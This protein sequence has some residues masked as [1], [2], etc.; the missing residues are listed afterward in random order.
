MDFMGC[1]LVEHEDEKTKKI[2]IK[3]EYLGGKQ[4]LN[5]IED[6]LLYNSHNHLRIMR[7]LA[8]L[9]IT[10]MRKYAEAFLDFFERLEGMK[11]I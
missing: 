4:A 6:C 9:S 2:E 7:I 3:V 5:R 11:V 10:G 1:Y 8:C